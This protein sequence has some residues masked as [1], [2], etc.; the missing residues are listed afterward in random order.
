MISRSDIASAES[1]MA[2][3][4]IGKVAAVLVCL[5]V[6][7]VY[8]YCFSIRGGYPPSHPWSGL[9]LLL[10][11]VGMIRGVRN[12]ERPTPLKFSQMY[13]ALVMLSAGIWTLAAIVRG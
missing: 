1:A 3:Y 4:D 9:A 8:L 10:L 11:S 6:V 12:R 2:T 7:V 5:D 13:V